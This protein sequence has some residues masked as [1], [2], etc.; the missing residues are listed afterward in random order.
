MRAISG[1]V[2]G[3]EALGVNA[4]S[5]K[6]SQSVVEEGNGTGSGLGGTQLSE[7]EPRVVVDGDV[8]LFAL[9]IC[10]TGWPVS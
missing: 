6:E 1:T 7:G 2:I 5:G 3:V 9:F 4:M 10:G 8:Q